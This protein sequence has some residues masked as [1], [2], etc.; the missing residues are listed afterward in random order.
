MTVGRTTADDGKDIWALVDTRIQKW[1]LKAEGWE[2]LL[3]DID[4]S[5][6]IIV[7]LRHVLNA[8]ETDDA[9]FDLELLDVAVDGYVYLISFS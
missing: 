2:D 1:E 3:M 4:V 6:Q 5:R 7:N 8:T 9:K